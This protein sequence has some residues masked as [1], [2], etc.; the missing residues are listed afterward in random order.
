MNV[1]RPSASCLSLVKK[2]R[3]C[4]PCYDNY[5]PPRTNLYFTVESYTV[6]VKS[7]F[8]RRFIRSGITVNYVHKDYD[9]IVNDSAML[10]IVL[11]KS[12]WMIGLNTLT[13]SKYD[14]KWEWIIG[15][16]Y[17]ISL[18]LLNIP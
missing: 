12:P 16:V 8:L 10:I 7:F 4:V 14:K 1:L 9:G 5:L 18:T 11:F 17:N 13:V 2:N 6:Y 3:S 15:T